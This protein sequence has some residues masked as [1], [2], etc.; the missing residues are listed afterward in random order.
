MFCQI[1]RMCVYVC[2]R[3]CVCG[4]GGSGGGGGGLEK[5]LNCVEAV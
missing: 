1:V 4:G 3:G 5:K 2:V